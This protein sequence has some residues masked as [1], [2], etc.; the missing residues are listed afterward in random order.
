VSCVLHCDCGF[1]ARAEDQDG[2][3]HEVRRHARQARGMELS[4]HEATLLTFRAQLGRVP[5][6]DPD[7][8][9]KED[10]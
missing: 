9:P 3:V 2:L 4:L 1:Q 6:P 8:P 7:S 10:T 5:I